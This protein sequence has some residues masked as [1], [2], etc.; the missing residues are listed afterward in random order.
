MSW[1]LLLNNWHSTSMPPGEITGLSMKQVHWRGSNSAYLK[2]LKQGCNP[3]V[4]ASWAYT[5]T[6][7]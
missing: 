5:D 1:Q 4:A 6:M 7:I 2:P 3:P